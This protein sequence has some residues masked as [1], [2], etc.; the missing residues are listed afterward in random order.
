VNTT[1][2][3]GPY[4]VTAEDRMNWAVRRVSDRPSRDKNGEETGDMIMDFIGYYGHLGYALRSVL[5][6]GLKGQGACEA[7]DLMNLI[8]HTKTELLASAEKWAQSNPAVASA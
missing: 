8:I 1:L 2:S 3:F 7:Q 4:R 6:D 5:D